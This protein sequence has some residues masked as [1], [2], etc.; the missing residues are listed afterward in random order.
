MRRVI[1]PCVIDGSNHARRLQRLELSDKAIGEDFLQATLHANPEILPVG[2]ID[3]ACSPLVSLGREIN[4]ID[5]L[6]VSPL[7][8]ITLVETKLWRN[9]EATRTVVAQVLDYATRM[10]KWSY[11]ELEEQVRDGL[12][13]TPLAQGGSLYQIV[14]EQFPEQVLPEEQFID[15]VTKTLRNARFLLLIVGDGIREGVEGLLGSLHDHP[16]RLFTFG[17]VE[18]QL[19]THPDIPG[20]KLIIPQVIANTVEVVRAV[21]KVRTQGP[22]T[23]SVEIEDEGTKTQKSGSRRTLSKDEFFSELQDERTTIVYGKLLNFA[24]EIGAVEG[25]RASSVSV[26]LPDPA[27]SNH[28]V[29]LFVMDTGG[30]VYLGWSTQQVEAL[31]LP[32]KMALDYVKS[33]AAVFPGITP[34]QGYPDQLSRSLGAAEIEANFEA[35][36]AAVKAFVQVIRDA[37]A[38]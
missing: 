6:F 30:E 31:S 26:Q 14:R 10:N 3:P 37:R 16:Q 23:V 21:V 20:S 28:N 8:R 12:Q 32:K 19:Y 35:F 17:M 34:R 2:E 27:G 4:N 15:E 36:T 38:N 5:N 22:A 13:P 29:T 7:G 11:V 1:S 24:N 18:I 9:P 33:V 25:W